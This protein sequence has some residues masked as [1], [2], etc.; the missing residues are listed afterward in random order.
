MLEPTS[1]RLELVMDAG[2]RRK[3]AESQVRLMFEEVV[4]VAV[5]GGKKALR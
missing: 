5:L 4:V 3:D 1:H 2:L